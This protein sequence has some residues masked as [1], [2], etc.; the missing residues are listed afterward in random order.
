MMHVIQLF[1][2]NDEM[3]VLCGLLTTI[4]HVST[5]LKIY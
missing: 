4:M 1:M 5:V 2:Q 3:M